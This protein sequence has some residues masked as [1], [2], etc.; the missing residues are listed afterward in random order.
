MQSRRKLW[1]GAVS[2]WVA[3]SGVAALLVAEHRAGPKHLLTVAP[4]VLYRSGLLRPQNLENVIDAFGIRTLVN[5]LPPESLAPDRLE[6]LRAEERI[7]GERGLQLVGIPMPAET[8]PT[9]AQLDQWL[10]LFDDEQN[11]PILVHCEFGVIRT[12]M[13]VAAYQIE[14]RGHTGKQALEE[15]PR[16]GHDIDP[17]RRKPLRDFV[18][19]YIRRATSATAA[20]P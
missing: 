12:G 1:V 3:A 2:L 7:A 14:K 4:K 17:P 5:L 20:T 8:P 6:L 15:M 9:Q 11:L 19:G 10:A 16:F 13:M 18:L